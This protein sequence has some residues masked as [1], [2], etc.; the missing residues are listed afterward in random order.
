MPHPVS[1]IVI[2]GPHSLQGTI[3]NRG[4]RVLDVLNDVISDYLQL[5]DVTVRR[6]IDGTCLGQLSGATI[7]KAAIDFVL[8]N[9]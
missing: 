4:L 9:R 8:L 1:V 6:G 2:A 3:E 5:H 7:P